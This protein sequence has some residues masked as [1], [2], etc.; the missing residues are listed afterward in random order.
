[1]WCAVATLGMSSTLIGEGIAGAAAKSKIVFS[2][3]T[4]TAA[5]REGDSAVVVRISNDSRGPISLTSVSSPRST[6]SMIFYDENMCQGNH[7][8]SQ[9]ANLFIEPGHAQ[10]LALKYQGAM[11]SGLHSALMRGET[12]PI[13]LRWSD[14]H[15]VHTVTL[16]AKVVRAPKGLKFLGSGTGMSGMR[17]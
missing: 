12:I 10:T 4:V 15:S 7:S 5:P 14:F 16:E 1:M 13:V 9:L 11:L 17:M 3:A 6:S 2:D 8:M